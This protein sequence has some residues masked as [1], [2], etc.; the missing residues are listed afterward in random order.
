MANSSSKLL[1]ANFYG[2]PG[3]GKSTGAAQAFADLKKAGINT[4]LVRE[5]AKPIVWSGKTELLDDQRKIFK[6]QNALQEML[7][8]QVDVI[9]TDSPILLSLYYGRNQMTARFKNLIWKKYH[10]YR[11]INFMLQRVKPYNPA[12][13]LQTKEQA[14]N[15]DDFVEDILV[16]NNELYF[17]VPGCDEGY[18]MAVEIIKAAL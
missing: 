17:K 3:I 16:A 12:G 10:S 9:T 6:K 13:R 4:E 5:V 18:K 7:V 1:V 2:G 8:G 14:I 15:I 11:N